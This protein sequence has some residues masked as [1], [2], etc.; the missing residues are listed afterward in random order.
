MRFNKD[1]VDVAK[2]VSLVY[3]NDSY[4]L[5]SIDEFLNF[6]ESFPQSINVKIN[7]D[8]FKTRGKEK[9]SLKRLVLLQEDTYEWL[10]FFLFSHIYKIKQLLDDIVFS[11]N[12]KRTLATVNLTRSL[13]EHVAS[14]HYYLTKISHVDEGITEDLIK[15]IVNVLDNDKKMEQL[16]RIKIPD[17]DADIIELIK[18]GI[19]GLNLLEKR[20]INKHGQVEYQKLL[21]KNFSIIQLLKKYYVRTRFNWRSYI[22]GDMDKF[23]LEW[24]RVDKSDPKYQINITTMI[25][26][27]PQEERSAEFFYN[28]LCD[29]VHPNTASHQ[30][31]IEESKKLNNEVMR[32]SMTDSIKNNEIMEILIHVIAIPIKSS[33]KNMKN[34]IT[35]L[36]ASLN[37]IKDW[38]EFGRT[39]LSR[40][41]VK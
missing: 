6:I 16:I 28:M 33:L 20:T 1:I 32:Y 31:V 9:N 10:S 7:G 17:A 13:M 37:S 15:K 2:K 35:I 23:F 30:L 26:K 39:M 41:V 36:T 4:L 27:F 22:K 29:F 25:Q 5:E 19:K 38:I 8:P 24:D 11:L 34:N 12:N 18:N 3:P 14:P 40:E 21:L